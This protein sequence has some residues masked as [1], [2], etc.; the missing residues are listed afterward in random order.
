MAAPFIWHP[1]YLRYPWMS[2]HIH[3]YLELSRHIPCYRMSQVILGYTFTQK[4]VWGYPRVSRDILLGKRHCGI[5]RDILLHFYPSIGL[6]ISGYVRMSFSMSVYAS[7]S[8]H[9]PIWDSV[10]QCIPGYPDAAEPPLGRAAWKLRILHPACPPAWRTGSST[11][12][13][14]S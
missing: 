4:Y 3:R 8:R 13:Y 9:M 12:K 7:L 2:W 11:K 10:S 14:Y 5:S 6:Y 1:D